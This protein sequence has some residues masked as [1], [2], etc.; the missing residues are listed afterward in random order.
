MIRLLIAL[1]LSGC[2]TTTDTRSLSCVG[3]CSDQA[4]RAEGVS[5]KKAP[6]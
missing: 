2:S 3:F 4:V 6:L 1:L 5:L